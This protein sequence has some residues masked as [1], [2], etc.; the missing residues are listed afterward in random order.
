ALSAGAPAWRALTSNTRTPERCRVGGGLPTGW[1]KYCEMRMRFGSK[2]FLV[3]Y[4]SWV[5]KTPGL[6]AGAEARVSVARAVS[7]S[8]AASPVRAGRWPPNGSPDRALDTPS[9]DAPLSSAD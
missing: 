8:R 6:A 5:H 7:L 2:R 3:T 1:R 9:N 4:V